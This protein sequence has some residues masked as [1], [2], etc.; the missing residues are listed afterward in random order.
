MAARMVLLLTRAKRHQSIRYV[1]R[2][3]KVTKG[4]IRKHH[5]KR[6][7]NAYKVKR[8]LIPTVQRAMRQKCCTKFRKTYRVADIPDLPLLDECYVT[9][10]TNLNHQNRRAH[11]KD[12][13]LMPDWKKF[14]ELPKTALSSMVFAGI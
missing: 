3:L 12:F 10:Q 5:Q 11:G 9:V 1:A 8:Q 14:D 13:S 6:Q 7:I 2:L 4:T